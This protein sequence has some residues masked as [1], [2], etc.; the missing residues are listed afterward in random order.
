MQS[1]KRRRVEVLAEGQQDVPVMRAYVGTEAPAQARPSDASTNISAPTVA[2]PVTSSLLVQTNQNRQRSGQHHDAKRP[3]YLRSFYWDAPC[4]YISHSAYISE[5]LSPLPQ[6]PLDELNNEV[7][8]QTIRDHTHLFGI[9]TPI[10][11]S[12][13]QSLLINHPNQAFVASIV[14][15]LRHGFWPWAETHHITYPTT[16]DY[17]RHRDFEP[18]IAQFLRDQRDEEIRLQ[19]FSP[20]FGSDLLPGM[21]A[22]PIHAIPKP[23]SNKFRL[24]TNLSAGEFAPNTMIEKAQVS[25][26]PMDGITE[27]GAALIDFRHQHGNIKLVMWKSDVSQAY[28]RMPMHE[29]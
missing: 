21:Y 29:R 24:I 14:N 22:M 4:D 2:N 20:A 11:I 3:D 7:V 23:H 5:T 13:L 12:R 17:Y 28:R 27:L 25:N 9:V 16:Q 10:N 8:S 6:V 15:G 26:L 1:R 19:R 18:H